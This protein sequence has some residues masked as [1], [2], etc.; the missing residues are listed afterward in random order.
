MTTHM[1]WRWNTTQ[2]LPKSRRACTDDADSTI[3][4]PTTTRALT[5]IA[6]STNSG[7]ERDRG[8][9][10]FRPFDVAGRR[11][12]RVRSAVAGIGVLPEHLPDGTSEV[13]A[14]LPVGLVPVERRAPRRQQ[15]SIT[16]LG[17]RGGGPHGV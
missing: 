16:R 11:R 1:A 7:V 12:V 6:S 2:E 14:P 3:T 10:G 17:V 13:V 15:N 9:F 8:D 5:S 4:R